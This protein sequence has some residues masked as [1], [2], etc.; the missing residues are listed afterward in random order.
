M[1]KSAC[2][3]ALQFSPYLLIKNNRVSDVSNAWLN[4]TGYLKHEILGKPIDQIW[5]SIFGFDYSNS[6]QEC[7][8]HSCCLFTKNKNVKSVKLHF[9]DISDHETICIFESDVHAQ[10]ET[11]QRL[12][13]LLQ[14]KDDLFSQISHELRTPLTVINSAVQVL[15]KLY[16]DELSSNTIKYIS[17]IRQNSLRLLRLV[18]NILELTRANAGQIKLHKKNIDIVFISKAII[19]SIAVYAQQKQ[20]NLNFVSRVKEKIIAIDDEKYERILLNLLSNAIKFTPEGKSIY[21]SI[22]LNKDYVCIEV[23]DEG[24]GIPKDKLG[25]IF[26][27]FGQVNN[28]TTRQQEGA[29]IG[30]CIVKSL[31]SALGGNICVSSTEGVGSTF[32]VS[33]PD[34]RIEEQVEYT[35]SLDTIK[36]SLVLESNVEFSDIYYL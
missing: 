19:E 22:Y 20:L 14:E 6:K 35:T 10:T 5:N 36:N 1:N 9:S 21:V 4:I 2:M 8:E 18:N 17:R 16:K 33:L 13:R 30:L 31:V 23:K 25:D 15:Q 29:G 12:E 24:V 27:R 32:T 26:N 11:I 28:L 3:F 34:V 7:I